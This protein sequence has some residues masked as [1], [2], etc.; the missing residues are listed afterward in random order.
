MAHLIA[1]LNM[2]CLI[3]KWMDGSNTCPTKSEIQK[4]ILSADIFLTP[5]VM[6]CVCLGQRMMF[7]FHISPT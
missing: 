7:L 2:F 4:G 5:L 6:V 3:F 1:A